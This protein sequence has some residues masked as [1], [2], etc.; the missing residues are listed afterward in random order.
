[1]KHPRR[2][3]G[4]HWHTWADV[5]ASPDPPSVPPLASIA[6]Q[7]LNSRQLTYVFGLFGTQ[8]IPREICRVGIVRKADSG[9][10]G[11]DWR[12][13]D[14]GSSWHSCVSTLK[15][16]ALVCRHGS[17]GQPDFVWGKLWPKASG[18][19]WNFQSKRNQALATGT[20]VQCPS[21]CASVH[22]RG[23]VSHTPPHSNLGEFLPPGGRDVIGDDF[24]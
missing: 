23:W 11:G 1:M 2:A 9:G 5:L 16:Q 7:P 22:S 13:L 8:S 17:A 4:W 18:Q 20:D 24:R 15:R 12:L 14:V 10:K 6:M 21:S 3:G 19:T